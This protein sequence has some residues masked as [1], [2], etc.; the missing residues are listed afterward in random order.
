MNII[1]I[2]N[3]V[4]LFDWISFSIFAV[5]GGIAQIYRVRRSD[6][7][8]TRHRFVVVSVANNNV[9]D[10]LFECVE[11]LLS[12]F[13]SVPY[14]LVDEGSEL[15]PQLETRYGKDLL[16]VVPSKYNKK[17]KAKGRAINYFIENKVEDDFWYS[18]VDDDNLVMDDKFLYEIPYYEKLGYSAMNPVLKPRKGRSNLTYIMDWMRYFDDITIFKFF[19]GLLRK[20]LVGMHGELLTVRGNKFKEIGFNFQSITEDFRFAIE[21]VKRNEKVWQSETI[22]FIKSP[23]NVSDLLKQRGRW[24]KGLLHDIQFAPLL[25]QFIVG[26]RL[27]LWVIGIF[28]S[29]A[30]SFLWLFFAHNYVLLTLPG[31]IYYMA[32]YI[33]GVCRSKKYKYLLAIPTFGI[34]EASS[35]ISGMRQKGFVV[36]NKNQ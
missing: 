13:D 2:L 6:K 4:A 17:L 32:V 33:I 1:E 8:T 20:P 24:F 22:V 25:M 28:G 30:L 34:I 11:H 3:H 27:L 31:G 9:K 36:I 19:L 14:I 10:A 15:I 35:F 5:L 23:N 7:K 21:L 18:I 12:N 29:W 16:V 26:W